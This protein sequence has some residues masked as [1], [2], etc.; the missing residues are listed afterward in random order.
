[1]P[2]DVDLAADD[3]ILADPDLGYLAPGC[4]GHLVTFPDRPPMIMFCTPAPE[5]VVLVPL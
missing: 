3:P 2:V 1:M 4:T 5:I